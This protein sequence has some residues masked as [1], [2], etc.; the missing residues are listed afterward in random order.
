[1]FLIFAL[2]AQTITYIK[3][4]H[5]PAAAVLISFAYTQA[6][7]N[8]IL[9]FTCLIIIMVI[10]DF[11]FEQLLKHKKELTQITGEEIKTLREKILKNIDPDNHNYKYSDPTKSH[12]QTHKRPGR[13]SD[14]RSKKT[15]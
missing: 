5:P 13:I 9:L 6:T 14:K 12:G 11:I 8:N 3:A 15:P 2:Y 1:M 10:I 7:L 4:E